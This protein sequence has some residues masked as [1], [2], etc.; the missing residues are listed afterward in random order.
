MDNRFIERLWR[1]VKYEDVYLNDYGDGLACG[2]GLG[3]WFE[4]YN[5]VRP[6][7][8][9]GQATPA[10][11]YRSAESYGG[12]PPTWQ[13]LQ[14]P[15]ADRKPGPARAEPGVEIQRLEEF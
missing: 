6:H 8:A 2:R 9:L 7:Q 10:Q 15:G 4:D 14:A 11:W 13:N 1:S 5:Q 3:R 12:K